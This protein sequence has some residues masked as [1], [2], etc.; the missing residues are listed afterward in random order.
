MKAAEGIFC[1]LVTPLNE[2]ETIDVPGVQNLAERVLEGGVDGILALGS[3]GEQIALTTAAK[4]QYLKSLR[5]MIPDRVP[6]MVGCGAT[7]TKLAIENCRQAEANGADAVIVTAPCFYPFGEEQLVKYYEEIAQATRLPLYLYNISRFVGTT[8]TAQL[9]KRLAK[10]DR[11]QGIK[12]S[13]RDEVLVQKLIAETAFR[14]N[15]SVIQGSDRILLKSF[16]WGC[17]A[18]VTVVG[19]VNASLAPRLYEAWK[20]GRG[21]EA[22]EIQKEI[23][24]YVAVITSQG[25]YPQEIK[26]ILQE[27]GVCKDAMTSPFLP[28]DR[29]GR[30]RLL[31]MW[32]ELVLT[33]EAA[34]AA[35]LQV[36]MQKGGR[37]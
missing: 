16:Q 3:T 11:V 35:G 23:L 18:G 26:V 22:A 30:A 31:K 15:F 20:N 29:V 34:K 13:D 9:V 19:N 27:L 32:K 12:E 28:M 6:L 10:D 8:L 7:S 5:R 24:D 14:D 36:H 21:E 2:D 33:G 1:A 4:E 17:R 37:K 25:C